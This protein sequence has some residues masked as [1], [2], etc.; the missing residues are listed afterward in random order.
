MQVVTW[1]ALMRKVMGN[2]WQ[3]GVAVSCRSV[4]L[5]PAPSM[6]QS[7]SPAACGGVHSFSHSQGPAGSWIL[8]SVSPWWKSKS[9]LLVL[10]ECACAISV[11]EREQR[12]HCLSPYLLSWLYLTPA[13]SSPLWPGEAALHHQLLRLSL[14][15]VENVYLPSISWLHWSLGR[16]DCEGEFLHPRWIGKQIGG[17]SADCPA[18]LFLMLGSLRQD[19]MAVLAK[20]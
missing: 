12:P 3:R 7:C 16:A 15:K 9:I 18:C 5:G 14:W 13:Q 8:F 6:S 19:Y 1:A 4:T 20:E 11:I 17:W 10:S 2:V